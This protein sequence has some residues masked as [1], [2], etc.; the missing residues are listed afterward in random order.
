MVVTAGNSQPTGAREGKE[1]SSPHG[2]SIKSQTSSNQMNSFSFLF[3][4]IF[5][6]PGKP[7]TKEKD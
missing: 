4:L 6:S 3:L 5:L 2:R 1:E 7:L